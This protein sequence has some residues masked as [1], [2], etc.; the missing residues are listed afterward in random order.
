M[1]RTDNPFDYPTVQGDVPDEIWHVR[2]LCANLFE[3]YQGTPLNTPS[4]LN[5]SRSVQITRLTWLSD[6]LGRP[7]PELTDTQLEQ[8]IVIK[9]RLLRRHIAYALHHIEDY[10]ALQD[11]YQ[12]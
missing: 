8:P 4:W 7:A 10:Y 5:A 1:G 9:G 12:G 3:E 11:Q 2:S 6:S